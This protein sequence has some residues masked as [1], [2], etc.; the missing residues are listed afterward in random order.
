M[1]PGG[2]KENINNK[3]QLTLRLGIGLGPD[4]IGNGG[5]TGIPDDDI[6]G[7]VGILDIGGAAAPGVGMRWLSTVFDRQFPQ[8]I[9]PLN[10]SEQVS[11]SH[12]PQTEH[13]FV[14]CVV[15]C[16]LQYINFPTFD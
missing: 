12:S 4:G 11:Q 1:I 14:P 7:G 9:R 3:P 16:V 10:S 6:G 13:V 5:G 8:Y 2:K 15:V